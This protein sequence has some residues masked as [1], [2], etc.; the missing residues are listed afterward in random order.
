MCF[1]K[2]NFY[3]KNVEIVKDYKEYNIYIYNIPVLN[4]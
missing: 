2:K 3:S 1:L 4:I